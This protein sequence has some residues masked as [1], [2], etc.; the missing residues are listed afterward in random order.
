MGSNGGTTLLY[1]GLLNTKTLNRSPTWTGIV[2]SAG[3]A[4]SGNVALTVKIPSPV[5]TE[6]MLSASIPAGSLVQ[7]ES[8]VHLINQHYISFFI[9]V[10]KSDDAHHSLWDS[11]IFPEE[12]SGDVSMFVLSLLVFSCGEKTSTSAAHMH[13]NGITG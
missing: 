12:T 10:M 8:R 9:T 6:R 5:T 1:E 11:L 3:G 7:S 13:E 2:T 4:T